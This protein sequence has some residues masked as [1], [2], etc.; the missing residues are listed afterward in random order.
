MYVLLLRCVLVIY[1][2]CWLL[3]D[4]IIFYQLQ[5]FNEKYQMSLY[6]LGFCLSYKCSVSVHTSQYCASTFFYVVLQFF[7]KKWREYIQL[8]PF[9]H[10]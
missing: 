7:L 5:R 6:Q 1:S 4:R 9:S 2:I 10:K 8:F 3:M